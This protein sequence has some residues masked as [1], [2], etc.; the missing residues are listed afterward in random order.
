MTRGSLDECRIC[1]A[2]EAVEEELSIRALEVRVKNV[3]SNNA[4]IRSWLKR[5]PAP[6]TDTIANPAE[7]SESRARLTVQDD[8]S[9]EAQWFA[10][11]K[12]AEN[13]LQFDAERGP[14]LDHLRLAAM[15]LADL[16]YSSYDVQ[17]TDLPDHGALNREIE[18]A[19]EMG[20]VK[21]I[22]GRLACAVVLGSLKLSGGRL[23]VEGR[24]K[25]AKDRFRLSEAVEA[26]LSQ[27]ALIS[28]GH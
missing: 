28:N 26:A 5:Q 20:Q 16:V 3:Q 8:E 12:A 6:R 1:L 11:R 18:R 15:I 4:A 7:H 14:S 21:T 22:I 13:A 10:M 27:V 25:W 24:A 17:G 23:V 2:K 19:R 9:L